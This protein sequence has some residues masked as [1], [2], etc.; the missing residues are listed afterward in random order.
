MIAA[1]NGSL[2]CTELLLAGGAQLNIQNYK[3]ETALDWALIVRDWYSDDK[4]E[5]KKRIAELLVK[6]GGKKRSEL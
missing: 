4:K 1:N 3:G 6:N 5:S 2:G